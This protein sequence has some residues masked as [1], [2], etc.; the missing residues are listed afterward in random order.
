MFILHWAQMVL[1]GKVEK[2][3]YRSAKKNQQHYGSSKPPEYDFTLVNAPVYL[4][5]S[6]A[7]WLGDKKDIEEYL[8]PS[9][10]PQY[11]VQNNHL[12][13]FNHLDFIWGLNAAKMIYEPIIEICK[14]DAGI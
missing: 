14:N 2:Y 10:P 4:Y 6:D 8:L 5:W 9:L 7:D 12:S 11:L 1:T 13:D 3:D